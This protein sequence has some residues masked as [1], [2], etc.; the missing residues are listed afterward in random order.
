MSEPV[1]L[2]LDEIIRTD[3]INAVMDTAL[4]YLTKY[5]DHAPTEENRIEAFREAN[6]LM[7]ENRENNGDSEYEKFGYA[8]LRASYDLIEDHY[9]RRRELRE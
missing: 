4:K 8:V 1:L 5:G 2:H 3:P 6:Q 9:K 7:I